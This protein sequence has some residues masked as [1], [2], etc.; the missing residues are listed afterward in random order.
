MYF[1]YIVFFLVLSSIQLSPIPLLRLSQNL[2]YSL[3]L[4]VQGSFPNTKNCTK[5]TRGQLIVESARS[6][7]PEEG[8]GGGRGLV[9]RSQ[10]ACMKNRKQREKE[11]MASPDIYHQQMELEGVH[12]MLL[13]QSEG[14]SYRVCCYYFYLLS[15]DAKL[16]SRGRGQD[17]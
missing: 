16:I 5:P 6:G 10:A 3:I 7:S 15:T 13:L 14:S 4:T 11:E 9:L 2:V 8:W 12:Q 17:H 1:L